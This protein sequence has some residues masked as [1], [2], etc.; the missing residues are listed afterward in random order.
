[1]TLAEKDL[2]AYRVLTERLDMGPLVLQPFTSSDGQDLLR[3][4]G[5][6]DVTEY[7]DMDPITSVAEA[8]EIIDWAEGIRARAEGVRWAIRYKDG[9]EFLGTAGFNSI[10]R[11]RGSRAEI[12]YD[13]YPDYW[14]RGLMRGI[15]RRLLVFADVELGLRRVEAMVTPGNVR[16]CRLLEACGFEEEGCLKQYGYWKGAFWDQLIYGRVNPTS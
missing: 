15:I 11:A 1:M 12:A 6:E 10:V 2:D 4:F 16:S 7:M 5:R 9:G 3:H 8:E 13:L 14:G